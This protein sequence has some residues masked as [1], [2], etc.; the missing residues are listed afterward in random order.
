MF[1][2][3]RRDLRTI[4]IA[5]VAATVTAGAPAVAHGVKHALF[6]HN[7]DKLDKLNS[8][9]FARSS[10]PSGKTLRGSYAVWGNHSYVSDHIQVRTP[11]RADISAA[12][13]HLLASG[14][15]FTTVCPGY[16]RAAAGHLCVYERG[17]NNARLP[18]IV[19]LDG[20]AGAGKDGFFVRF[21][22]DSG[23][24]DEGGYSYGEWAVKAA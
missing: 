12:K 14:S 21:Y 19:T 16:G 6:A 9:A 5:V 20:A 17:R 7:A 15:A 11:L 4:I 22:I 8:S 1:R 3:I 2:A 24:F 18:A 23:D 13:V 10:L